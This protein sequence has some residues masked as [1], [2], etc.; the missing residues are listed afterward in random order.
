MIFKIDDHM[1]FLENS[2]F[3]KVCVK[4]D[5]SN[6]LG[7]TSQVNAFNEGKEWPKFFYERN[8]L[9]LHILPLKNMMCLF[10]GRNFAKQ[11]DQSMVN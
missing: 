1:L 5:L 4:V 7:A 11:E 3:V 6:P 2:M 9:F 8:I 10:V